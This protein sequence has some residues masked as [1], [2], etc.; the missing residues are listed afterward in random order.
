[1]AKHFVFRQNGAPSGFAYFKGDVAVLSDAD[2]KKLLQAGVV[3][4]A[5]DEQ[6]E[7]AEKKATKQQEARAAR[8]TAT[9]TQN[10]LL[11]R[12]ASLEKQIEALSVSLAPKAKTASLNP[13]A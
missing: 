13:A 6:V 3:I 12:I 4:P 2:S 11:A 9:P 7:A 1:M 5:E 10:G 8:L